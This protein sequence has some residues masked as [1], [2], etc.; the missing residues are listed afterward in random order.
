M[1]K[2]KTQF[3]SLFLTVTLLLGSLF[4]VKADSTQIDSEYASLLVPVEASDF[5][6]SGFDK[7]EVSLFKNYKDITKKLQKIGEIKVKWSSTDADQDLQVRYK[8]EDEESWIYSKTFKS[9]PGE[10]KLDSIDE[11]KFG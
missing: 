11:N 3:S 6:L 2:S 7:L 5:K 8:F 4:N 10:F 9:K 1:L